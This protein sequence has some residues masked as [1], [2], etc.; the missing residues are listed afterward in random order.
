MEPERIQIWKVK[1][2]IKTVESHR[3]VN[4]SLISLML[5][6]KLAIGSS[7]SEDSS[8]LVTILHERPMQLLM[9]LSIQWLPAVNVDFIFQSEL[10]EASAMLTQEYR[11]ASI[12]KT[13]ASRPLVLVALVN[14]QQSLKRYDQVP[15]NGL[16]LFVGTIV[17]DEGKEKKV[18]FHLE[19]HKPINTSLYICDNKFYTA[20]LS[21]L[22]EFDSRFGFIVMDGNGVLFG[23]LAGDTRAII[24]QFTVDLSKKHHRGGAS[25]LRFPRLPDYRRHNYLVKVTQ[26]AV[27]HF[28]TNEQV[29][30]A[31]IV[32]AGSA[33]F[34]A[35]LSR[36]DMFDPRLAAK[37]IKVVDVSHGGETGF[38]QA[39]ELSADERANFELILE[40][41]LVRKYLAEG[42]QDTG[43]Y[44]CG[45][46]ETS[47]AL[48]RG[49]VET[50]IVWEDLDI[51]RY[52]L[53][54]A[55]GEEIIVYANKEQEKDREKFTDK[56]TGLEMEPGA[57]PQNLLEW[58][59]EKYKGFGATLELVT[60]RSEE[61]A[62][63]I[64]SSG[65][66]GGLLRPKVD[67]DKPGSEEG[68]FQK[69]SDEQVV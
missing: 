38:N 13:R 52:T 59:V 26:H 62:E 51:T 30:V 28:I 45:T 61:G 16:V 49:V 33:D 18:S 15:P 47:Q 27:Q 54:N 40:K 10:S 8:P 35:E 63:F 68:D 67:S 46:E 50:L 5:P 7:Q 58:L 3:G 21:E 23:T 65:G 69:E 32:L 34:K 31:G 12:I 14:A 29:N 24:H 17:T 11:T 48:D 20:G 41:K 25:A 1:Q 19:P 53:S 60:T 66:I 56:S 6:A 4:T 37:A 22:L 42:K 36:S 57:E 9:A 43:L 39:I 2:L 55:A 64:K 44:C